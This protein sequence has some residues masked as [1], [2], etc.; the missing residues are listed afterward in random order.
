MGTPRKRQRFQ[1]SLWEADYAGLDQ[2]A[3][4]GL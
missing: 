1:R 2:I 3:R 4:F